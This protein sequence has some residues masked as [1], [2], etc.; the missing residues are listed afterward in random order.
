MENETKH[1]IKDAFGEEHEFDYTNAT[2][3][4]YQIFSKNARVVM[5]IQHN[6]KKT[7]ANNPILSSIE[8]DLELEWPIVNQYI[9]TC[10]N[11]II[12]IYEKE[13]NKSCE[14]QEPNTTYPDLTIRL[15][16]DER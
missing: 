11:I 6:D 9:P 12:D 14:H 5:F 15:T 10:K 7:L 13:F 16:D 4:G 8:N 2:H 3:F 1:I